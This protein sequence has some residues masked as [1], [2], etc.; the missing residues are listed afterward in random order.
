ML[1]DQ[2]LGCFEITLD[3]IND[4]PDAVQAIMAQVIV[5]EATNHFATQT[6]RYTVVCSHFDTLD[7]GESVP[8]YEP[9]FDADAGTVHWTRQ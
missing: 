8:Y 7:E 5:I 2:R 9:E 1:K 6:I 4:Y 3:V